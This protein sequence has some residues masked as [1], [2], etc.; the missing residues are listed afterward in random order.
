MKEV[1]IKKYLNYYLYLCL[2]RFQINQL[3]YMLI[4]YIIPPLKIILIN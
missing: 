2:H 1:K 4:I 3:N